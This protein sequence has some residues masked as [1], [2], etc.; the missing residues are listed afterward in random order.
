MITFWGIYAFG[1]VYNTN[2][3]K[4]NHFVPPDVVAE[5]AD[6]LDKSLAPE[7]PEYSHH[8][9]Q[10]ATMENERKTLELSTEASKQWKKLKSIY[11]DA[12][13]AP[14]LDDHVDD[15]PPTILYAAQYDVLR[16][17]AY[18]YAHQL[19]QAGVRVDFFLDP[20][21]HHGQ[22]WSHSE[23]LNMTDAIVNTFY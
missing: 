5:Y 7:Y 9:D 6:R 14:L 18:L 16:D 12:R 11:L 8:Q 23:A 21:G 10:I 2:A 19:R 3:M 1:A 22:W 15:L 13:F 20:V 4:M 17:D